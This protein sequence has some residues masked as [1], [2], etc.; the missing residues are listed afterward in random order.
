M[1]SCK[2]HKI[3]QTSLAQYCTCII[4]C[5]NL[6]LVTNYSVPST[7]WWSVHQVVSAAWWLNASLMTGTAARAWHYLV[8]AYFLVTF[9]AGMIEVLEHGT[10][11]PR[12]LESRYWCDVWFVCRPTTYAYLTGSEGTR[13]K[14]VHRGKN[15][16]RPPNCS[17]HVYKYTYIAE[18]QQ[19]AHL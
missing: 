18:N 4:L 16:L 5:G 7:L 13:L 1:K 15:S 19:S 12:P 10:V 17:E 8:G 11:S 2:T 14:I 9:I 6:Q 3:L